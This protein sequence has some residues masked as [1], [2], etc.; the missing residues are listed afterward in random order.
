METKKKKDKKV[1][2][3]SPLREKVKAILKEKG[4]DQY[5][6]AAGIGK[7]PKNLNN[8]LGRGGNL[9][10]VIDVVKFFNISA[11]E[12]LGTKPIVDNVSMVAEPSAVYQI[13]PP[14][15]QNQI[16]IMSEL[17]FLQEQNQLLKENN[18][19][20]KEKILQLERE[21]KQCQE[22]NRVGAHR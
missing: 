3:I 18:T 21:L 8:Q 13:S 22:G 11:D 2:I 7:D 15:N 4:I 20:Q 10:L 19:M 1:K 9:E 16:D 12:L 17:Q 14:S 6:L 5:E